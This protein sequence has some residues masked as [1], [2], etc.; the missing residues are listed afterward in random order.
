MR[1]NP[2]VVPAYGAI[3]RLLHSRTTVLSQSKRTTRF[4][5]QMNGESD[6]DK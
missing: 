2:V 5:N 6:R 3:G 4:I 1:E